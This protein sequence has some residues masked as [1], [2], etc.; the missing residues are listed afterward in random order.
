M[1]RYTTT[2]NATTMRKLYLIASAKLK[3]AIDESARCEPQPGQSKENKNLVG[4]FGSA[5][6]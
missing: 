4:H 3:W 5:V 2:G 6:V 1:M